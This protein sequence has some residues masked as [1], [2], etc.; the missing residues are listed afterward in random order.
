MQVWK[1]GGT[2]VGKPERMHAIRDLVTA[3]TGR[4]IVVLSALS[5]T[6]NALIAISE[7]AKANSATETEQKIA[8]LKTHYDLFIKELYSTPESLQKGQQIV[9]NEFSYIRS[10]VKVKAF[11]SKQDKEMV[12][13]GEIL[14]TQLF[15]VYMEEKG[16][17]SVLIPALDF[18]RIDTDGEPELNTVE[19]LLT[20]TLAAHTDKQIVVT[21]GFICRNPRGE[22]DNLKRGGSDYTASLIG[23]AIR[24]EEIQ[25]WTDIDG[26][27]NNDPRIVK[28]TFPIRELSFEEAAELAYFGAKI[29]HPSTITPAK[30]RGVPVRLKNT[31]EPDAYGT[32]IANQTT[33][34]EIKAIAAK[35][36]L[37]AIYIHSTRMLNA[38]GFLKKVF[39]VFEKYKTPV[40][41]ITTSEVS[42]AVTIDNDTHLEA[43]TADLRE[44]ADLEEH[45]HD[46]SIICVV[47]E[48]KADNEGIAL[49]VFD[50]MKHIPIRMISYGAS[51]HNLSILVWTKDKNTALNALNERLFYYEDAMKSIFSA[52]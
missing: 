31:M 7:L 2:S 34:R 28:R 15:Q 23:G 18:M 46:L 48:F 21:Q 35:D 20:A 51:E 43:I 10:L 11:T 42:V 45:D 6:T 5:G 8:D 19:A 50:A 44:F 16:E 9:E 33:D 4:K 25:I 40:D 12:A 37:T 32:L 17:S 36:G 13:Q 29:L 24:A 39:D 52:Q 1:F 30:M 41:M 14:S 38:F 3:N 27:H 47:G 22:V 49:K 26:M